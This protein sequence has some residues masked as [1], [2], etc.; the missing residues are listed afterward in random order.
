MSLLQVATGSM[1]GPYRLI[2][3]YL[4]FNEIASHLGFNEIASHLKG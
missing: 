3:K 2:C 1:R 4:G